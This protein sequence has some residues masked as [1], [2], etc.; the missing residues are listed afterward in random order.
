MRKL[1][2][3]SLFGGC[4]TFVLVLWGTPLHAQATRSGGMTSGG[5]A[6]SSGSGSGSGGFLNS[7]TGSA[8]GGALGGT[9]TGASGFLNGGTG[10]GSSGFLNSGTGGTGLTGN[11]TG[12]GT[13][14]G[15]GSSYQGISAS[16]PFGPNYINLMTLGLPSGASK[17]RFGSPLYTITTST[18]QVANRGGTAT[19]SGTTIQSY[20]GA[21][22]IGVRRT[23]A[24]STAIGFDYEP[25]SPDS[26]QAKAQEVISRASKQLKSH[27]SIL[28]SLDGETVVLRGSAS[29]ANER[30]LAEALV[31]LTPGIH[32][33]R[34]ELEVPELAPPPR[35]IP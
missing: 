4:L 24:Y 12:G 9:G 16:N 3:V 35:R 23:P 5:S 7:G 8:S 19:I 15:G 30:R 20:P 31:R 18:T 33:V 2:S 10:S 22:S 1:N 13:R 25:P 28:V 21:T 34:N 14:T 27:D 32:D 29:N 17:P 11:T 6:P 26:I